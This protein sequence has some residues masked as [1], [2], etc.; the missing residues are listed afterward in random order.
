MEDLKTPVR[1]R[2]RIQFGFFGGGAEVEEH[3]VVVL[4]EWGTSRASVVVEAKSSFDVAFLRTHVELEAKLTFW[5][6]LTFLLRLSFGEMG[7]FL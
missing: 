6:G 2:I 4:G 3:V 7:F 1:A 5:R